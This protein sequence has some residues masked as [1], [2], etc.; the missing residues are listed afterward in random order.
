MAD[1]YELKALLSAVDNMSPALKAIAQTARSTRKYLMDVGSAA[2]G[3]SSSIGLPFAALAGVMGGFSL[4]G[5]KNAVTGFAEMSNSIK[6]GAVMAGMSTKQFQQWKYVADQS[7]ISAESLTSAMGKLNRNIG[8][9]ASGKNK[10]LAA[11]FHRLGI[12]LR[13]VHNQV[14]SAIDIFPKLSDAF[15]RNTNEATRARMGMATLGK[16]YQEM[17]PLLTEGALSFV[18]S[19]E[20]FKQL[21]G[22]ISQKDLDAGDALNKKLKDLS[23]VTKGFGYTIAKELIPTIS[24]L[25]EDFIQWAVANK[26]L[27][28]IKVKEMVSEL[29]VSLKSFDWKGFIQDVKDVGNGFG[30]VVDMVGGTKNALIGL[31][32]V[33]NANAITS[34]LGLVGSLMRLVYWLGASAIGLQIVKGEFS[35]AGGWIASAG[36][37]IAGVFVGMDLALLPLTLVVAA[38]ALGALYLANNWDTVGPA[39][40]DAINP[41]IESLKELWSSCKFAF[42]TLMDS[43]SDLLKIL[44]PIVMPILGAIAWIIGHVL[45]ANMILLTKFIKVLINSLNFVVNV[46]GT[47][48]DVIDKVYVAIRKLASAVIPDWLK[49]VLGADGGN[50]SVMT[51][52][53]QNALP[54]TGGERA[55]SPLKAQNSRVGGTIDINFN[56][57]PPGLRIGQDNSTGPVG[58][59]LS[60]GYRNFAL[61]MP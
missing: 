25:V 46:F 56:N 9:A 3:V 39:I 8:D 5:L 6:D 41:V 43:F 16:S 21:K 47:W 37:M 4:A 59:N 30:K 20:R 33:M 10:D 32:V 2:N 42:G 57:A 50:E 18:S 45:L 44:A 24:P 26:K 36:K 55:F 48:F 23:F 19:M 34:T 31:A 35:L 52:A 14:V 53:R 13:D 27:V 17:M 11:L 38:L 28:S 22:F 61:G 60:T 1:K 58:L 12:P 7:D 51:I 54:Q 49:Y 29:V 40:M 15:V